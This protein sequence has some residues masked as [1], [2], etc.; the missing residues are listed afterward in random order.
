[1]MEVH[2]EMVVLHTESKQVSEL[3]ESFAGFET[4]KLELTN[5]LKSLFENQNQIKQELFLLRHKESVTVSKATKEA[6][7]MKAPQVSTSSAPRSGRMIASPPPP[8]PSVP[9][10]AAKPKINMP[11]EQQKKK[12]LFIG[13]SISKNV[14][15]DVLEAATQSEFVTARAYSSIHDTEANEAKQAARFPKSNFNDVVPAQL[16]KECF[17]TLILQAGS[18]DVSNLNTRNNPAKNTEYFKQET[19]RSAKNLFQSGINAL[20]S[21]KSL[22]KVVIMKQIPRYDPVQSDPSSLKPVL[23]ELYNKTITDSWMDCQYK[24]KIIIGNY[25]I[26]CTGAIRE[27]RYRET[28][29]NRFDGIHMYGSSGKKAYTLSVLNILKTAQLTSSEYT[30]HQ[31]C[32]QYRYQEGQNRNNKQNNYN[33][34]GNRQT[35]FGNNR[36]N[37]QGFTL[38]TANRFQGL[39]GLNQGN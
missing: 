8:P 27:A 21:S 34:N 1:M 30:F 6:A 3:C 32:P 16:R 11:R 22:E 33:K 25:N 26:D 4:F 37:Q 38:P 20:A 7:N 28:K 35:R 5:V 36:N 9:K 29:T 17:K 24:D 31:S 2:S 18:V 39:S 15:I 10:T 12:T 14:D 13:D 19:I 23:S